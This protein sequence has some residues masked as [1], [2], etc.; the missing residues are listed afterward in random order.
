MP[1]PSRKIPKLRYLAAL[2]V[3]GSAAIALATWICFTLGLNFAM[4]ICIFLII[5]VLLS[6]MDSLVSSLVFSIIAVGIL[7]F[8]F[9]EP[10]F[11]LNVSAPEDI[12][13]LSAFFITSIAVTGLVRRMRI[14]AETSREQAQL[15]DLTHDTIIIRDETE[16]IVFWNRAAEGL[17][18]WNREEAIG[19]TPRELLRSEYPMPL[20]DIRATMHRDGY[21][22]GEL[23]IF[24]KDGAQ[25]VVASRWSPHLDESGRA[26]GT[27]SSSNDITERKRAEDALRRS[28][29]AYLAEAQ[30]LSRTGSFGW[31]LSTGELTWS[32]Q[33][34]DIFGYDSGATPSLDL[35]L[36]RVHS[37]DA[38][39]VQRAFSRA[40]DESMDFNVEFRL[41]MPE[42]AIKHIHVVAHPIVNGNGKQQFVGAVMD[43]TAA[44][45][46]EERLHKTQA[47][48][49]Y[50]ARV[51]SLGALS[52]SIA[53][54]INQPPSHCGKRRGLPSLARPR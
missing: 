11:T 12:A 46:A 3:L 38:S 47:E 40:A 36:Q 25:I 22:E 16:A 32:D 4:T 35:M 27:L 5:I 52:S 10:L 51:I 15:L 37:D 21:W 28:Q 31:N 54:E 8:F 49:A 48:L 53:H 41:A 6:L 20:E 9:T 17:Y 13:G 14:S 50:V 26:I 1:D 42:G 19:K 33:S 2:W 29:A 39:S 23:V 18:E 44:K 7:N 34:F 30:K 24:K 43:I 45:S